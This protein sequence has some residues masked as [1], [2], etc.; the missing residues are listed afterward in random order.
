MHPARGDILQISAGSKQIEHVVHRKGWIVPL[1]QARYLLGATYAR[2]EQGSQ[3]CRID[4]PAGFEART[5]LLGR[6]QEFFDQPQ[7]DVELIEQRAAVRPA[8]YDRHPLIGSHPEHSNLVC[9]N[10]LGSKGSLMAP[11]LAHLLL[12]ELEFRTPIEKVLR[13]D[14]RKA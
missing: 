5:E 14:R 2:D 1:G 4:S 10:G 7:V 6:W 12:D 11:R 8:S 13:Y 3:G 9:L